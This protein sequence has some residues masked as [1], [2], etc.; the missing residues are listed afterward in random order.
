MGVAHVFGVPGDYNLGFC[1]QIVNFNGVDWLGNC[2]ELNAAYAADGYARIK[3]I[4]AVLTTYGVGEL[5]AI[6]GIAGSFAEFVPV[7]KIVGAPATTT[8]NNNALVHHN[9]SEGDFGVFSTMFKS[10]TVFQAIID[11][12]NTA[13]ALIDEALITCWL[14][15]R[16]VYISLPSDLTFHEITAPVKPLNLRYPASK[17]DAIKEMVT[18][19]VN[20][21]KAA[22]KPVLLPTSVQSDIFCVYPLN[23]Y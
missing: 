6:N 14:K 21:I 2:N 11:N 23:N 5:S 19:I 18:H 8:Q 20:L 7:V 13:A 9:F 3:G 1:D 4:S 22:K 16:P 17:T 12:P 10:V 15:K